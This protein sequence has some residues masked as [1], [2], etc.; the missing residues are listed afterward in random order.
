MLKMSESSSKPE[1][2]ECNSS[3]TQKQVTTVNFNLPGDGWTSKNLRIKKQMRKKNQRL[4]KKQRDRWGGKVKL[5]PNV[6][7]ERV[8]SWSEAK[9]LAK[10][11]GKST[12]GYDKK[13]I[14][15]KNS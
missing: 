8:E 4:D 6:D 14:K 7:G 15:E 12:S 11:K 2:P 10:S 1:C 3:E 5:A 13:I 9:K